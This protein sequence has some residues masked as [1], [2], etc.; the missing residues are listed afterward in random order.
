MGDAT[1]ASGAPTRIIVCRSVANAAGDAAVLAK[2]KEIA[3]DDFPAVE[4]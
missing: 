1:A 2:A 3:A 4:P